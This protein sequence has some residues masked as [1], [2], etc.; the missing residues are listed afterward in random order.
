MNEIIDALNLD[1][2]PSFSKE[3]FYQVEVAGIG[4]YLYK[5]KQETFFRGEG[6]FFHERWKKQY[7]RNSL[8]KEILDK[9][10]RDLS[11]QEI[12]IIVLKG[13]ALLD[14]I[15]SDIGER[16]VSDI[17]ILIAEENLPQV[18]SLLVRKYGFTV[19]SCSRWKEND[20]KLNLSKIISGVEIVFEIHTKLFTQ[21]PL[22]WKYNLEKNSLAVEDNFVY[23]MLHL[24]HQHTFLKPRWILDLALFWN[25]YQKS[26]DYPRIE[27]LV[28]EFNLENSFS[29]TMDVLL[30]FFPIQ[31][32]TMAYNLRDKYRGRLFTLRSKLLSKEFL[33]APRSH[34]FRYFLLK[35]LLKKNIK[36]SLIYDL[37][38]LKDKVWNSIKI[39]C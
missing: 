29:S 28:R 17:D 2:P 5:N 32:K 33:G 34:P 30:R 35:H 12:Q 21:D 18:E 1:S 14:D 22:I 8:Q 7:I 13:M 9:V 3:F 15:Y 6:W 27:Y 36:E 19:L 16:E 4:G 25:K 37:G 39:G 31:N 11:E 38:W 26:W 23:L 24:S 10:I 20:Y